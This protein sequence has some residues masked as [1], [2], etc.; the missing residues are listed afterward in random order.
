MAVRA[1]MY[2]ESKS[3]TRH[4][5]K[6]NLRVVTR[7]EDNKKWAAATP[8]GTMELSISNEAALASFSEDDLMAG[9]EYFVTIEKVPAELQ[10]EEG[11]G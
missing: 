8:Y 2:L 3:Q 9:Q 7:G 5:G 11:M 1:K 10:G 4:G 6:V